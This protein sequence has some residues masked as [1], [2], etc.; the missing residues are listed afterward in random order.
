MKKYLIA[1]TLL[2]T[3][4]GIAF[5]LTR[6]PRT[7]SAPAPALA[8]EP[9]APE[10]PAIP[11][12]AQ[13]PAP[14]L[15]PSPPA[16]PVAARPARPSA[17]AVPQPD[18]DL[19]FNQTVETLVSPRSTWEQKQAAF[20]QLKD[21]GKLD[22][23]ISELEHRAAA[24]PESAEYPAALGQAYLQKSSTLH[25]VREQGILG[26]KADLTF[27]AALKT[28]PGNWDARFMKAVALSYWPVEMNR[29]PEVIDHFQTLIHQ[30]EGQPAQ[31]Q[32]AQPYLWLG[33]QYKKMGQPDA[34][35]DA[36]QRGAALFPQNEQLQS[37]LAAA[38]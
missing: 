30:Q 29:G 15:P 20:K 36:W 37:R 5:S 14:E 10:A 9:A 18:I 8:P 26:M 38:P 2:G 34:A 7:P 17:P 21:A 25:D 19:A 4:A 1:L 24:S 33:D 12:R 3:A 32:F 16:T 13:T 22:Q 35:R 23:A 31:S 27:D 11:P 28:D 6:T